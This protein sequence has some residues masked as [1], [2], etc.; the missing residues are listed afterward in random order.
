MP[1]AAVI[2]QVAELAGAGLLVLG[3]AMVN[4]IGGIIFAGIVLVVWSNISA[5]YASGR[6]QN[7]DI[8]AG[9]NPPP[10]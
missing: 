10:G 9:N 7:A 1:T 8:R 2:R 6:S 3:I 4:L 5:Y